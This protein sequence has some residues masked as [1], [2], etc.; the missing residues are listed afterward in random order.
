MIHRLY[1]PPPSNS[2]LFNQQFRSKY[3]STTRT[4]ISTISM[5]SSMCFWTDCLFKSY[6][7]FHL[8]K[9][10]WTWPEGKNFFQ[11][12]HLINF[13]IKY[14]YLQTLRWSLLFYFT[15][16]RK[17]YPY[18]F[19]FKTYAKG[20]WVGQK[21]LDIFASEFKAYKIETYVGIVYIVHLPHIPL[22]QCVIL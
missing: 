15:G 13:C 2:W 21:M 18:F 20:R 10:Y 12:L 5:I 17:V 9:K 3:T 16:L 11:Q 19:T 1:S 14:Y 7:L 6:Y 4:K 22:S 8:E